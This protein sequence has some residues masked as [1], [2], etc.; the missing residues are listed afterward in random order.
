MNFEGHKLLQ[1]C[2]SVKQLICIN[3]TKRSKKSPKLFFL[4][5][6]FYSTVIFIPSFVFQLV[7]RDF[8][9]IQTE[10][11]GGENRPFFL[12]FSPIDSFGAGKTRI[13]AIAFHPYP[14]TA[15]F[16]FTRSVALPSEEGSSPYA[17]ISLRPLGFGR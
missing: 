6:P 13:L 7:T 4:N 2:Q 16:V 12:A 10:G 9:G 1:K 14:P 15:H 3:F 8:F 5:H 11:E 17:P